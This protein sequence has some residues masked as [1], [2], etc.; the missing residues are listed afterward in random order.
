MFN[1]YIEYN[2][3][4]NPQYLHFR[5]GM[6]HSNYSLKKL[7]KTFKLQKEL[8]KTEMKHYEVYSDTWRDKK[9]EWLIYVKSD[10]LCTAFSY[11]WNTK[12]MEEITGFDMKDCWSLP[13]LVWKYFNSLR[14]ERDELIYTYNDKKMRWLFD[15]VLKEDDC[16]L[17]INIINQKFLV[18]F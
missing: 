4:Q 1:C 6:T 15:T 16:V 13:G 18:I 9:P 17:S 14:T 2:E 11:A 3:K 5:C 10:V 7:G 12:A 8:L